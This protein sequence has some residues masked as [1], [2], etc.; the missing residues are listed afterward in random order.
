L[1]HRGI[2]TLE[3]PHHKNPGQHRAEERSR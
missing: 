3:R 2:T 1:E